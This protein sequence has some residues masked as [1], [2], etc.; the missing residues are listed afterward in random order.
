MIS[1][2]FPVLPSA[3]CSEQDGVPVFSF[4]SFSG[5]AVYLSPVSWCVV[6]YGPVIFYN[7]NSTVH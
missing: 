5:A 2:L 1:E 3:D 6:E 7:K 4:F